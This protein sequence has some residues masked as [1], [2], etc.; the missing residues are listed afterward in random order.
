M[1]LKLNPNNTTAAEG[2]KFAETKILSTSSSVRSGPSINFD[3]LSIAM[4]P[5]AE[6]IISKQEE[7]LKRLNSRVKEEEEARMKDIA[8]M[9]EEARRRELVQ[10]AEKNQI[11]LALEKEA[12]EK[13]K[14]IAA[15]QE[16]LRKLKGEPDVSAGPVAFYRIHQLKAP[17]PY[18]EGVVVSQRENYL[19]DEDFLSKDLYK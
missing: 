10:E 19:T 14:I 15:Q 4:E 1:L 11:K 7:E 3:Q 12:A 9:Q 6:E 17:G 5:T 8:N 13:A 16:E 2:L 18:P